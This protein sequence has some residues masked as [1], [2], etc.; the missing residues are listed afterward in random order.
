M[1]HNENGWVLVGN[2]SEYKNFGHFAMANA[3]EWLDSYGVDLVKSDT[4]TQQELDNIVNLAK[5][6][7]EQ[8][9]K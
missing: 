5:Y 8:Y 9:T 1:V 7:L 2:L 6:G 4:I 3:L